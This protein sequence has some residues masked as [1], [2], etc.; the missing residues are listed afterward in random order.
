MLCSTNSFITR[1]HNIIM[2]YTTNRHIFSSNFNNNSNSS[3]LIMQG[4]QSFQLDLI[5]HRIIETRLIMLLEYR[6]N[7]HLF[8]KKDKNLIALLHHLEVTTFM[9]SQQ[10]LMASKL[11]N[12]LHMLNQTQKAYS[13]IRKVDQ[14]D[15][16]SKTISQTKTI[17][18]QLC[19]MSKRM[20]SNLNIRLFR[21]Y[22]S[23]NR[24]LDICYNHKM[25]HQF[26]IIYIIHSMIIF[27]E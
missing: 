27:K 12:Q 1:I 5:T 7:H 20:R 14:L 21:S 16:Y 19:T 3:Q 17:K 23:N 18:N 24:Y 25:E 6:D 22:Q 10:L 8:C 9:I 2:P 13:N 4:L 15:Y 11:V 26:K